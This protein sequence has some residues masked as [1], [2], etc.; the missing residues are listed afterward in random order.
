MLTSL[1]SRLL[2][3]PGQCSKRSKETLHIFHLSI[4]LPSLSTMVS[5]CVKFFPS[6]TLSA[7]SGVQL[8]SYSL[9][10]LEY[11]DDTTLFCS[12]LD[13]LREALEIYQEEPINWV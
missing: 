11:A 8:G 12:T 5:F 9:T 7:Y 2:R 3:A 6:V 13:K 10:D 1:D 4:C